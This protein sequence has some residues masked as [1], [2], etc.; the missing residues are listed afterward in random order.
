MIKWRT[1]LIALIVLGTVCLAQ[2]QILAAPPLQQDLNVITFPGDSATVSGVVEIIGTASHPSFNSYGVLYAPGPAPT[3]DSQWVAIN[4]GVE[5]Q[6]VGGSLALWDTTAFTEDGQPVVPNGIY[7]LAL[8]RYRDGS[9]E[10]DLYYVRNITVNN[11]DVTPTPQSTPEP[12]PT[13][14]PVTPTPVPVEQPPTLT[15]RPSDAVE[16]EETPVAPVTIPQEEEPAEEQGAPI[17]LGRLRDSFVRGARTTVILFVI[18]GVYVI[19]RA[20]VR[21]FLRTRELQPPGGN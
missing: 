20:A 7:T 15:P 8:A 3:G 21:Y 6:V 4:F 2:V 17:D 13:A 10:P 16:P 5:Q 18:W 11:E 14:N 1:A 9:S 19:G 12:L